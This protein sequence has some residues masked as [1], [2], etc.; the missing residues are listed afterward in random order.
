MMSV[1]LSAEQQ[2]VFDR[3]ESTREHLFVT[4]RAGTGKSTLLNHLAWNTS[5][6]LAIC[7]PTGVAALNVG[8]QTI[9]SLFRLPIGLIADH[10]IDQNDQ[11]RKLLNS[12]DTLVV[13]E[14]SMV[15]A[16]LMDA[17]DRSLRQARQRPREPF[18][19]VQ[20]VLFGD[21]YQLAP[22]PGSLEERAYI[23][24][25]YRSFW[26]FDAKVWSE[27]PLQLVE[28][29]EIHRQHE[30]EFK[31]LLNG[32]R[33]GQVTAEMAG[34]LN[35]MGARIPPEDGVI[36]LASRNDTVDRINKAA[37]AKLDGKPLTA[38][39]E[40]SGDF[41]GRAFPADEALDLKVG[42][43]VM[44]LRNDSERRW[45]NGTLG[46][47]VKIDST[48]WV[49]VDGEQFEVEPAT[50]EKY[51]YSYS[52]VT[53]QLKR[54]IVAEFTQFPLRLAW[55]VTIHKSQGKTYDRAIVDLG[56]RAFSPGQSY[57]ALSR[58]STLDGLYLSRP[59]RPSDIIVDTDV[60]RFMSGQ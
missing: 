40:V 5:K 52:S 18:G 1:A 39:A 31:Y 34:R 37:L 50:W 55:A 7:A 17:M 27:T 14:V 26:F 2:A 59:L 41:G 4:G 45:V 12:I 15:S 9:H 28:L 49:E 20:I 56:S 21:P 30:A 46:T 43:Q 36:T 6:Q 8:G 42:A 23:A 47:V 13:D 44:F 32:V 54:D 19:G 38:N 11:T 3:I 58:I 51:K 10:T 35:G 53:K 60:K 22:V 25:T 57:V 24:D 48:V 29:T 33:H 16:D